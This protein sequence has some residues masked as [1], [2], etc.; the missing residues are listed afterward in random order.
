M[1]ARKRGHKATDRAAT[2]RHYVVLRAIAAAD[3]L[4][5]NQKVVL[6]FI[7]IHVTYK[8]RDTGFTFPNVGTI[9]KTAAMGR[10]TVQRTL[11]ELVT[12][13]WLEIRPRGKGGATQ[14]SVYRVTHPGQVAEGPVAGRGRAP[15]ESIRGPVAGPDHIWDHTVAMSTYRVAGALTPVVGQGAGLDVPDPDRD[16][17][18]RSSFD[19]TPVEPDYPIHDE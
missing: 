3:D 17:A 12:L 11:R 18:W 7:E 6:V 8:D 9:A 4:T 1:V 19:G 15:L 5:H 14:S 13:N 16:S 2:N 10:S